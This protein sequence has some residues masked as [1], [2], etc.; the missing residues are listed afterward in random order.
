[1]ISLRAL[2]SRSATTTT[3]RRGGRGGGLPAHDG[4]RDARRR[5]G[6]PLHPADARPHQHHQHPA[7]HPSLAAQARRGT[8]RHAPRRLKPTP[9][10]R[11]RQRW[12]GGPAASQHRGARRGGRPS[13]SKPKTSSG[14]SAARLASG[15]PESHEALTLPCVHGVGGWVVRTSAPGGS[16]AATGRAITA[17]KPPNI[18]RDTVWHRDAPGAR[19]RLG[20]QRLLC[21]SITVHLLCADF[22]RP[23]RR[24]RRTP[25]TALR[26][27]RAPLG[28]TV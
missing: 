4:D 17:A 9:P 24:R 1:M 21:E 28:A 8:R 23:G 18:P 12:R 22:S 6:H 20:T 11:P 19:G 3:H 27:G 5:R 13:K 25:A 16:R 26:I 14:T 15:V 7:L 10:P 2:A